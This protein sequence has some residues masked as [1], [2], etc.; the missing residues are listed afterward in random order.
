MDDS[1]NACAGHSK[2]EVVHANVEKINTVLVE[3]LRMENCLMD[4]T[5][6][7]LYEFVGLKHNIL[8]WWLETLGTPAKRS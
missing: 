5:Q 6:K 3:V 7:T 2:K 4:N 8:R 1:S